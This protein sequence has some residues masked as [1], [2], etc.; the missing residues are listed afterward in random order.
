MVLPD[1]GQCEQCGADLKPIWFTEE[2][3]QIIGGISIKT[4]RKR[5]ACSHL[6]CPDCLKNYCV[7]DSFDGP[8]YDGG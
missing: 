6:V 5:R 7:D 8:Y 1:Y 3:Y 4:G 2:E